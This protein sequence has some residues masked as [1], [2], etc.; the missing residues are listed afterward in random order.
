M[1]SLNINLGTIKTF[2]IANL[3]FYS[4]FQAPITFRNFYFYLDRTLLR[5]GVRTDSVHVCGGGSLR[6][7]SGDAVPQPETGRVHRQGANTALFIDCTDYPRY[8]VGKLRCSCFAGSCTAQLDRSQPARLQRS[9]APTRTRGPQTER[10]L[11]QG[12]QQT[13]VK[14]RVL[15]L[16]CKQKFV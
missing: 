5:N 13:A 1:T 7:A 8:R 2:A 4:L 14:L 15:S 10:H 6:G 16:S 11:R 3:S 12:A 9:T